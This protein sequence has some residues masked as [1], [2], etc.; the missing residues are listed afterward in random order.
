MPPRKSLRHKNPALD[1]LVRVNTV[2]GDIYIEDPQCRWTSRSR[3]YSLSRMNREFESDS[4]APS[5]RIR[6]T[7]TMRNSHRPPEIR[8]YKPFSHITFIKDEL[9]ECLA[10]K[11]LLEVAKRKLLALSTVE[12]VLKST[13]DGD[14]F[15]VL[16]HCG[17]TE[18]TVQRKEC[19]VKEG[20]KEYVKVRIKGKVELVEKTVLMKLVE[21]VEEDK[22]EMRIEN[23]NGESLVFAIE[24][25][26]VVAVGEECIR[27]KKDEA[28]EVEVEVEEDKKNVD[29][30]DASCDGDVASKVS[31]C[32]LQLQQ[33]QQPKKHHKYY[34]SRAVFVINS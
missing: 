23:Y 8:Q 6:S 29:D 30:D 32:S 28:K 10:G 24:D 34:I 3:G 12:K 5:P 2:T 33:V 16:N 20:K 1:P 14:T 13:E 11:F 25:V 19:A 9:T 17:N 18:D 27:V 26:E 31:K 4:D 15:Y 7:A 21:D 22:N